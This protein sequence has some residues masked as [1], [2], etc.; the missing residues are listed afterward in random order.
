[1]VLPAK[2]FEIKEDVNML[3]AAQKLRSF[4]EEE[5]YTTVSGETITLISEILDL[6]LEK[7]TIS[8]IFSRDFVR[9]RVY[10]RK[11]IET[12]VTEESPFWIKRFGNRFFLIVLAPS[13]ARGIKKLLTNYVANKMSR[14]LFIKPNVILE[15]EIPHERLKALH[16][17]NP[18][19]TK[20]IWFDNVDIPGVEKLCLAGSDLADTSLYQEYLKHG[21]IWYVV[22][23]VQ[24]RGMV[25]GV[26][27]NCVVTLFSK[28]SVEEFTNYIM[29]DILPLIG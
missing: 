3:F 8:G 12:P 6:K 18:Q 23:E 26:T 5:P 14:I 19:A 15:V 20:L 28:S 16:E 11:I 10:R 9:S 2:I 13:T 17:S 22:F 24:K 1:M 27:R 4:R 29:E 21:K 25:V 7:D